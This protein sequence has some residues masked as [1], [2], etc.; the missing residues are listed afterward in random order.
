MSRIDDWTEDV[1]KIAKEFSAGVLKGADTPGHLIE[2]VQ[3]DESYA[4][5]HSIG[6]SMDREVGY[7]AS[8]DDQIYEA[9]RI[10]GGG[11]PLI[12]FLG[13]AN[14]AFL[15]PYAFTGGVD[16]GQYLYD[17]AKDTYREVKDGYRDAAG[18]G[19]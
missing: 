18:A 1:Q 11:A 2:A 3:Y 12:G 7:T 14:P 15:A 10:I 4:E 9:G 5:P 17:K 19:D 8:E 16:T 13:T 6:A